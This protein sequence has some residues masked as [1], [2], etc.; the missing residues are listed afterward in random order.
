MEQSGKK[1]LARGRR[2]EDSDL[3][4]LAGQGVDQVWIVDLAEDERC[5]DQILDELIPLAGTGAFEVRRLPGG[6]ADFV[7]MDATALL[8]HLDRLNVLNSSGVG[9]M[10]T[11]P[12]FARLERGQRFAQMR[13]RPFA[14]PKERLA[15]VSQTLRALGPCFDVKPIYA[16]KVAVLYTD[17]VRPEKARTLFEPAVN[18]RAKT[19]GFIPHQENCLEDDEVLPEALRSAIG[20][21]TDVLLIAST[22]APS[23]PEDVIGRAMAACGARIEH[24]LAPVE[25]GSMTMVG[26]AG[27]TAIVSAPGCFRG[28]KQNVIDLMLPPLLARHRL[29]AAAL[30][31]MGPGGL[32]E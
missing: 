16:P 14:A 10:C 2:L 8:L 25:P 22:M 12:Q 3:Q 23:M 26:Y 13:S 5:E 1:I 19:F 7:S 24:Y 18:Q 32:L 20:R 29:S 28:P 9:V 21:G 30:S 11:S 6:R 15:A 27:G 17:P 4:M 31:S